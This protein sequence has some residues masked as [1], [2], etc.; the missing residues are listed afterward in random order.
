MKRYTVTDVAYLGG[1][2][3]VTVKGIHSEFYTGNGITALSGEK[4]IVLTSF[5]DDEDVT[6]TILVAGKYEVLEDFEM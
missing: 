1:N 4:H 5:T 3:A 2:T 6:T